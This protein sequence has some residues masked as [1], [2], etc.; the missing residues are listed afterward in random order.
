MEWTKE[1]EREIM[2]LI[3]DRERGRE[4]NGLKNVIFYHQAA[5]SSGHAGKIK[6]KL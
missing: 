3:T 5:H 1:K 4:E 2:A 6:A